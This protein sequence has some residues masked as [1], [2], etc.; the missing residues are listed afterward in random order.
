MTAPGIEYFIAATDGVTT[1]YSGLAASPFEIAIV[2]APAVTS[3]TPSTGPVAGGTS[4]TI[5]G[6]NFKSGV[7]VMIGGVLVGSYMLLILERAILCT[8]ALVTI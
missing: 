3:I 7:S 5:V 1:I 2:D 6:S 4:V 8:T